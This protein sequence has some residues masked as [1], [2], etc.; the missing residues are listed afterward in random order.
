MKL[1]FM[2]S[3]KFNEQLKNEVD[4]DVEHLINQEVHSD[5]ILDKPITLEELRSIIN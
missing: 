5:G 4:N 3:T 1:F 2:P